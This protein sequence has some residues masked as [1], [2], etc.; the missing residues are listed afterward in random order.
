[1]AEMLGNFILE[2]V[3]APGTANFTLGTPVAGRLAFSA[4]ATEGLWSSGSQVFYIAD[5]TVQQE[6]G[7]GT[8]TVSG[9]TTTLS[10]DTVIWTS[11]GSTAK[12]NFATLPVYVYPGVP[13]ERM[14]YRNASGGV[15]A[16]Y[17]FT[18]P[19]QNGGPLAGNRNRLINSAFQVNQRGYAGAA[20]GAGAYGHDCWKAGAGGCTYSASGAPFGTIT[21]TAGTL[22]QV[23]DSQQ[24]EGGTYTLSW[25]GTATARVDSGAYAAS[26]ITVTGLSAGV[27]H[28]VEFNTGT[29]L[30]PQFEPGTMASQWEIRNPA[31]EQTFCD[32][33]YTTGTFN[34][35]AYGAAAQTFSW[36]IDLPTMMR[37]N[38]TVVLNATA[39]T[40]C[41]TDSLA[42]LNTSLPRDLK[43]STTVTALGAIA[44][45]GTYT[46]SADL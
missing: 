13:A 37:A 17:D 28:V 6:W 20:L 46:C 40:N 22:Q 45:S 34:F 31:I 36:L 43:L 41:G 3:A 11:A 24:V 23:V 39:H 15:V 32:R 9:G 18:M 38:P 8:Y 44:I 1:M 35:N 19:T 30:K 25:S 42:V 2:Q 33:R 29:V 21:I 27:T 4:G 14:V 12:L 26:P 16:A 5:D 10:R 7:T